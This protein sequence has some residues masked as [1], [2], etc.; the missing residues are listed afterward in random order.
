MIS[1]GSETVTIARVMVGREI[2][3]KV[4]KV[5]ILRSVDRIK[6]R[7]APFGYY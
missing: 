4:D 5:Y 3:K 7:V 6:C 1:E 2:A